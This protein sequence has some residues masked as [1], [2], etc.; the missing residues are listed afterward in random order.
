MRTARAQCRPHCIAEG[1]S[2]ISECCNG[3]AP[4]NEV[5]VG[6]VFAQCFEH[7]W[8]ETTY[9]CPQVA[10][11]NNRRGDR[12]E[13]PSLHD[14]GHLEQVPNLALTADEPMSTDNWLF[15]CS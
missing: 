7:S 8:S 6:D 11:H 2:K 14:A 3:L 1:L 5:V 9:A 4:C 13:V 15:A 12:L 10:T